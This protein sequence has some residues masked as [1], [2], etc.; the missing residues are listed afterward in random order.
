MFTLILSE[1][2]AEGEAGLHPQDWGA[3]LLPEPSLQP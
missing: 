2:Q 3:G 1:G